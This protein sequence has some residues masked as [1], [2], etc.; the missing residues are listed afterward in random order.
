MID[1]IHLYTDND[2]INNLSNW[3]ENIV[4]LI[5]FDKKGVIK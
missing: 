3:N 4:K 2:E 1:K 5:K